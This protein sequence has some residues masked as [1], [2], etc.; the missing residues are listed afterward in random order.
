MASQ[1]C[2]H[3]GT[4]LQVMGAILGNNAA[5]LVYGRR[6]MGLRMQKGHVA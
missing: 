4:C 2:L 5:K 3:D 1:L 6:S